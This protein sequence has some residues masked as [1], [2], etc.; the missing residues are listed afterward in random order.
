MV[1]LQ[2]VDPLPLLERPE[3]WREGA[4]I[5][6]GRAQPDQVGDDPAHLAGD[7]SQHL[8]SLGQLQAHQLLHRQGQAYVIRHGRQVVGTVGEGDD[9]VV[10]P[11]FT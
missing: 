8:A 2:I 9:L 3:E 4:E 10:V 11:I 1:F 5:D 6:A 7:H